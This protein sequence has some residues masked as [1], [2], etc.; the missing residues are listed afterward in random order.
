METTRVAG[1]NGKKYMITSY[2][3]TIDTKL[4]HCTQSDS[5]RVILLP[6]PQFLYLSN[7]GPGSVFSRFPSS[8]NHLG[9]S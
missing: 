9:I 4:H 7:E 5:G 8:S 6:G 2:S 3:I 1:N